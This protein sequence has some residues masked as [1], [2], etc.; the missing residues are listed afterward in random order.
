MKDTAD[1]YSLTHHRVTDTEGVNI[2]PNESYLMKR[3]K[4]PNEDEISNEDQRLDENL[5]ALYWG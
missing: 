4:Q 2:S 1:R 3:I 5:T